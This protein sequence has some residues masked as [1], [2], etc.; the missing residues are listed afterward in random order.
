MGVTRR[1]VH[2][3]LAAAFLTALACTAGAADE[4]GA[5]PTRP[6]TVVVGYPPGG[7]TDIIARLVAT[8]PSAPA[9][10]VQTRQPR[11]MD[12]GSQGNR[13]SGG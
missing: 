5:Y 11:C 6:I 3:M 8:S 12:R 4:A 10:P 7:A 13:G 9:S 2:R 1:T